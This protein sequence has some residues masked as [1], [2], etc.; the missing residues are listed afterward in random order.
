MG[1]GAP[2]RQIQG[3]TPSLEPTQ[4]APVGNFRRNWGLS[5][6]Y[7]QPSLLNSRVLPSGRELLNWALVWACLGAGLSSRVLTLSHPPGSSPGS[8][9]PLPSAPWLTIAHP[10]SLGMTDSELSPGPYFFFLSIFYPKMV[11]SFVRAAKPK[12]HK[13][14]DLNNGNL[15]PHSPGSHKSKDRVLAGLFLLRSLSLACG[16]PST[17]GHLPCVHLVFSLCMSVHSVGRDGWVDS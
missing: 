13:L 17:H 11:H 8:L 15:F 7:I 1:D 12:F 16:W 9:E 5:T 6:A 2:S 3:A 14:D 10:F 4:A